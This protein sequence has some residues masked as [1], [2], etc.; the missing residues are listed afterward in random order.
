MQLAEVRQGIVCQAIAATCRSK[1]S[2]G[3]AWHRPRAFSAPNAADLA[4]LKAHALPKLNRVSEPIATPDEPLRAVASE[5]EVA[6]PADSEKT[7]RSI[8]SHLC[9]RKRM[10]TAL[11]NQDKHSCTH[12]LD[13][14]CF[15]CQ[16]H[17]VC[18]CV[19]SI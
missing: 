6:A 11:L 16:G 3:A 10:V 12:C 9:F 8:P 17:G 15:D 14:R 7:G 5:T 1:A 13:Q 19:I 2:A 4:S 18:V